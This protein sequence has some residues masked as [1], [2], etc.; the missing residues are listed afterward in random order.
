MTNHTP[1]LLAIRRSRKI[2]AFGPVLE[3]FT[4]R[5]NDLG[6]APLQL[7][8]WQPPTDAEHWDQYF[9]VFRT[10]DGH[11]Q[12]EIATGK[13]L[14]AYARLHRIGNMLRYTELMGHAEFQ[15][16]GVMSLLHQQVVS[17]LLGRDQPWLCGIAYLSYGAL[18]QGSDGL[19][20]WK[21]KAQFLPY[22]LSFVAD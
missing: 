22:R 6:G 9:G 10:L 11:H 4:L 18:E 5:L 3:A 12:G 14:L 17:T 13:Q 2:R 20:F 19:I 7:K 21:R 16:Q 15:A 8:L 1:D